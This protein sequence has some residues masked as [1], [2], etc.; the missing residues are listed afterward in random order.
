MASGKDWGRKPSPVFIWSLRSVQW[1]PPGSC[2]S[3]LALAMKNEHCLV[4]STGAGWQVWGEG[5]L[6]ETGAV[7]PAS[8]KCSLCVCRVERRPCLR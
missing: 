1:Q 2:S 6:G 5:R 4:P 8:H 7:E 3:C